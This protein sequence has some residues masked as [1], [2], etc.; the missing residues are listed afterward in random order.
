MRAKIYWRSIEVTQETQNGQDQ[1]APVRVA[2]WY[3]YI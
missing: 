1:R 2:V 3:D